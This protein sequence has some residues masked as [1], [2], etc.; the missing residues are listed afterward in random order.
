[1][2]SKRNSLDVFHRNIQIGNFSVELKQP[3][4]ILGIHVRHIM[5]G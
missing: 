5:H 2:I 1:M 4:V 3:E